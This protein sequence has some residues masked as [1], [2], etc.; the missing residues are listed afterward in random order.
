MMDKLDDDYGIVKAFPVTRHLLAA[1]DAAAKLAV[2][3]SD[4]V[5]LPACKRS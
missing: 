3:A 5:T 1:Y 2:L 4:P